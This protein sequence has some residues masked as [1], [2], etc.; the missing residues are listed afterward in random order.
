MTL[1]LLYVCK[2]SLFKCCILLKNNTVVEIKSNRTNTQYPSAIRAIQYVC[3][4]VVESNLIKLASV[5]LG[6]KECPADSKYYVRLNIGPTERN[7]NLAIVVAICFR[8]III[9][10]NFSCVI[11]VSYM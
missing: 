1:L 2:G 9:I 6:S 11:I 10:A 3:P 8:V 4:I 7:S 5:V